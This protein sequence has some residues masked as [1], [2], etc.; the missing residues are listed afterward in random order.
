MCLCISVYAR[1]CGANTLTHPFFLM[2]GLASRYG[3][4]LYLYHEIGSEEGTLLLWCHM[5][6][7]H[8]QSRGFQVIIPSLEALK[9]RETHA[10]SKV[11]VVHSL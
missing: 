7:G 6:G 11:G 1:V 3:L 4:S 8:L 9:G 2:L 10:R 5:V